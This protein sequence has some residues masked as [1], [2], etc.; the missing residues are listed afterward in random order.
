M[1]L[2]AAAAFG[3]CALLAWGCSSRGSVPATM[4]FRSTSA[5][6]EHPASAVFTY[7]AVTASIPLVTGITNGPD[8]NEWFTG[9]TDANNTTRDAITVMQSSGAGIGTFSQYDTPQFVSGASYTSV[10][11]AS[12]GT[13]LWFASNSTT[14]GGGSY[15]AQISTS[16]A[17]GANYAMPAP[18]S[19][20]RSVTEGP[21]NS[22]W[23]AGGSENG[24]FV[25]TIRSGKVVTFTTNRNGYTY[26][27]D[28]TAGPDGNVWYLSGNAPYVVGR[29][30]PSGGITKFKLPFSY[31]K[32]FS[33]LS[34]IV[35]A[36]GAVWVSLPGISAIAEV[37]TS[38]VMTLFPQAV[39]AQSG[40][41]F[42]TVSGTTIFAADAG[43]TVKGKLVR[44][45]TLSSFDTANDTYGPI[46]TLK[47]PT[48][49]APGPYVPLTN[50]NGHLWFG[51]A[52]AANNTSGLGYY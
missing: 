15:V 5:V 11:I 33:G 2:F 6:G 20:L 29:V 45:A 4:Q 32:H 22:I 48:Y 19:F 44:K 52:D 39:G 8:G 12:D 25:G 27:Q 1:R 17:F 24:A 30:K 37:S 16:G 49:G 46:T 18:N 50:N 28:L 3:I 42:M 38:G 26:A 23:F 35:S 51:S 14:S 7:Y 13:D 34:R 43:F 9:L 21:T 47:D 10:S 31:T 41:S 36:N 40:P